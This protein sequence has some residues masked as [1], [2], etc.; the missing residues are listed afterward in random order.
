M[1]INFF[2]LMAGWVL[3]LLDFIMLYIV[4]NS[5]LG[6]RSNDAF[7]K[8]SLRI[9]L[10]ALAY[11]L[12]MGTVAYFTDVRIHHVIFIILLL[13]VVHV[14]V[15]KIA[16]ISFP[17]K[18]LIVVFHYIIGNV[19]IVLAFLLVYLLNLGEISE[20]PRS[21]FM[22]TLA[23]GAIFLLCLKIDLNKLFIFVSRKVLIKLMFFSL[24]LFFVFLIVIISFNIDY[25][26]EHGILVVVL[27]TI[28]INCLYLT[29]K[30]AHEYMEVMPNTYHDTK[31]LLAILN[32]K[33]E[34]INDVEEMKSVYKK[35][36]SL[37]ELKVTP[38][39]NPNHENEF[40]SFILKTVESIKDDKVI[41]VPIA[42]DIDYY[43]PHP[44]VDDVEIAYIL[45]ILFKNAIETMTNKPILVDV[46]SSKHAV[47]IKVANEAKHKSKEELEAMLMKNYS[48][49]KSVGRG[50]GLAKL[51]KLVE[52]REGK[53]SIF[54]E[55]NHQEQVNYLSVMIKF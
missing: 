39:V 21:L 13:V 46:M 18:V 28:S 49:K 19:A 14:I 25:V 45:G 34:D 54:Q 50:F 37:M 17:D 51:K 26:L 44:I 8:I 2:E 48:T 32:N 27:M 22:Y 47:L 30:S 3:N 35:V 9:A 1:N 11:G 55:F 33:L 6:Y 42:V 36:M 41:Q 38:E 10:F 52:K 4:T 24:T 15:K 16:R 23:T 12:A 20:I 40:E 29:L 43:E 5:L 7:K 31:E 53:L